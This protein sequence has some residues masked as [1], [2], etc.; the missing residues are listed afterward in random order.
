MQNLVEQQTNPSAVMLEM[1]SFRQPLQAI[2]DPGKD[3]P[4]KPAPDRKPAPVKKPAPA[5][6][7]KK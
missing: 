4:S 2:T 7:K 5:P 1:P 6:A 3:Q